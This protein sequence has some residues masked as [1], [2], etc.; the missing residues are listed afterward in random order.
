MRRP[1]VTKTEKYVNMADIISAQELSADSP[2]QRLSEYEIVALIEL[3]FFAYRDFVSDPDEI[4]GE[5][6]FGRA[7]HRVI[8][9]VGRAPGM[10]VQQLLDIL[11][12]TKQSLGRVLKELIDKGY[13]FQKE[14]EAD[15]RQRLLHLTDKGEEL[16]QRLM[17]PQIN[18]IRRAIAQ[19]G[20][21]AAS[22]YRKVLYHMVS[23]ENR[24]NVRDWIEMAGVIGDER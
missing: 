2:D 7:H 13:V 6:D 10:T 22:A 20:P 24:D 15:R 18:R 12:I 4:L 11:K 9:F 5:F 23:P 17:L 1:N 8:H 3:L 14:G 19:S 21:G 16:R